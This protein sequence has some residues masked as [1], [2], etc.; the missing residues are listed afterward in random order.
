MGRR[1]AVALLIGLAI[2]GALLAAGLATDQPLVAVA[3][4]AAVPCLAAAWSGLVV[5]AVVSAV[6]VIAGI[7]I[8]VATQG[9]DLRSALPVLIGLVVLAGGA[10]IAAAARDRRP[11]APSRPGAAQVGPASGGERAEAEGLDPVTGLPTRSMMLARFAA[12]PPPR[13]ALL[14][15]VDVDDL[16]GFNDAHGRGIG[17]TLLFAI[18]GRTRYALDERELSVGESS[19]GSAPT[20][21]G[22]EAQWVARWGGDEF[23]VVLTPMD[24]AAV[25]A[26]HALLAKVNEHPIR[27]DAGLV[28]ATVGCGAVV[29]TPDEELLH[30]VS[31]ARQALHRAKSR[32]SAALEIDAASETHR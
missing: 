22:N 6:S 30:A 31:R 9:G 16:A 24:D 8:T 32:G 28:P 4:V 21:R 20:S 29:W 18:G 23:L 26:L 5:V 12:D 3:F 2:S 11:R 1:D 14:A 19:D 15:L 7:A 10:V 13:P 17:D 27:S 25:D